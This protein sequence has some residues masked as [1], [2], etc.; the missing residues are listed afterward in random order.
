MS[1]ETRDPKCRIYVGGGATLKFSTRS[2]DKDEI[3]HCDYIRRTDITTELPKNHYVEF[4]V[5]QDDIKN[6]TFFTAIDHHSDFAHLIK[7]QTGLTLA[8]MD[9]LYKP[10]KCENRTRI[11]LYFTQSGDIC[12]QEGD[13]PPELL[14]GKNL[15]HNQNIKGN[16]H[17]A[18]QYEVIGREGE[19]GYVKPEDLKVVISALPSK[20]NSRVEELL[21][22]HQYKTLGVKD[23]RI[24]VIDEHTTDEDKIKLLKQANLVEFS[25]GDQA[26]LLEYMK[27]DVRACLKERTKDKNFAL[28]TTSASSTAL[29]SQ[30]IIDGATNI[31]DKPG[32]RNNKNPCSIGGRRGEVQVGKGLGILNAVIDTHHCFYNAD[33]EPSGRVRSHRLVTTLAA[34]W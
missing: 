29:S 2:V 30:M 20:D 3:S 13:K 11:K 22:R 6:K 23:E 19:D 9:E 32:S 16:I 14:A 5:N 26:R 1:Q 12:Y 24:S 4:S 33:G 17:P 25:G 27:E 28:V 31:D 21:L 10:F 18:I 34:G 8:D 7:N 15:E